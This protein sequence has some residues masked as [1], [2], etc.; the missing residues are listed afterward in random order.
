ML[1]KFAFISCPLILL[2]NTIMEY[3]V[4]MNETKKEVKIDL[5][6]VESK[7][8]LPRPQASV[9]SDGAGGVVHG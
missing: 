3:G 4:R 7:N 1:I 6:C 8:H 5:N 9:L 2:G